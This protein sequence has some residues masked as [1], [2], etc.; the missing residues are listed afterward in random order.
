V[1]LLFEEMT[2]SRDLNKDSS[3]ESETRRWAL[4]GT[5]DQNAAYQHAIAN[6]PVAWDN[7]IRTKLGAKYKGGLLWE[8]EVE[9]GS[10]GAFGGGD[11]NRAVGDTPP[12]QPTAPDPDEP[13]RPGGDPAG[14]GQRFSL[15]FDTSGQSVTIT[16]SI[17]TVESKKR[18]GGAAPDFKGAIGVSKDGV[19][20]CEKFVSKMEWTIT[21]E[22]AQLTLNDIK[23]LRDATGTVNGQ[24]WWGNATGEALYLGASGQHTTGTRWT[25]SHKLAIGKNLADVTICPGLVLDTVGAW[26]HLW[27]TY[28]KA[29]DAGAIV[30]IPAA[31]YVEQIYLPSLFSDLGIGE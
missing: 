17:S 10:G 11:A 13:L 5:D 29:E 7:L 20:G 22:R 19:K 3:G 27:V 30:E 14:G 24:P 18:G 23:K 26:N 15:S 31:A 1:P 8:V 12:V 4:H 21:E 9:Y 25:L 28:E 16:Q 6:T 2:E